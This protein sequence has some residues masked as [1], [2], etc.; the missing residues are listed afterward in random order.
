MIRGSDG[1][2]SAPFLITSLFPTIAP[3]QAIVTRSVGQFDTADTYGATGIA[4]LKPEL[5]LQF[6][7]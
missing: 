2:L 3:R 4:V 6:V 5:S 7:Q 1:F